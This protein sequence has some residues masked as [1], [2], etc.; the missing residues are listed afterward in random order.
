MNRLP[1]GFRILRRVGV[2]SM[3]LCLADACVIMAEPG[4][5]E[6]KEAFLENTQGDTQQLQQRKDTRG[7]QAGDRIWFGRDPARVLSGEEKAAVSWQVLDPESMLLLSEEVLGKENGPVCFD[8]ESPYTNLWKD[9]SAKA[10]CDAFFE[11]ALTKAQKEAVLSVSGSDAAYETVSDS[12]KTIHFDAAEKILDKDHIFLL[13]AQEAETFLPEKESRIGSF[14]GTPSS[15]WL[16]SPVEN[17][18][19]RHLRSPVVGIVT[20]QET[21]A[22]QSARQQVSRAL[23]IEAEPAGM[24]DI[25]GSVVDNTFIDAGMRPALKLDLSRVLFAFPAE[26]VKARGTDRQG[27]QVVEDRD[28]HEWMLTIVD[29]DLS[30]TF[31]EPVRDGDTLTISYR[32]VSVDGNA[33]ISAAVLD[34]EGILHAFGRLAGAEQEGGSVTIDLSGAPLDE[35][36]RLFLFLEAEQEADETGCAGGWTEIPPDF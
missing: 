3:A 27:L 1:A 24:G 20:G 8:G 21:S 33:Y 2:I 36:E 26:G 22:Y 30:V 32:D 14:A 18:S 6:T 25:R 12:G 13:S 11:K 23:G 7:I 35:T 15:W 9:S 16:R 29:P 31:E 34:R 17:S 4:D 28:I 5:W 10:W 19:G